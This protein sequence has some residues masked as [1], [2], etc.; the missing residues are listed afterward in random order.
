MTTETAI[1]WYVFHE[2]VQALFHRGAE[3]M[4]GF[5]QITYEYSSSALLRKPL[6][7]VGAVL[8]IFG[9]AYLLGQLDTSIGKRI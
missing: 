9:A 7:I 8:S 5:C 1:L 4:E 2:L 3:L 6:V